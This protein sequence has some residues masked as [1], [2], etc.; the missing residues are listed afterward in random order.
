MLIVSSPSTKPSSSRLP[1]S[2]SAACSTEELRQVQDIIQGSKLPFSGAND[3]QWECTTSPPS[4]GAFSFK[5]GTWWEV[6]FQVARWLKV[7]E[8]GRRIVSRDNG[9]AMGCKLIWG[10]AVSTWKYDRIYTYMSICIF[11]VMEHRHKH[12]CLE[13]LRVGSWQ[14]TLSFLSFFFFPSPPFKN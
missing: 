3:V 14:H 4:S 10:G 1:L 11:S 2:L 7:P 9:W 12:S 13:W 5:G 6:P 8:P